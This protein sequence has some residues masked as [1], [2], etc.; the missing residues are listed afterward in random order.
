M[1]RSTNA[2]VRT[3][4]ASASVARSGHADIQYEDAAR[5][6]QAKRG[7]PCATPIIE[8]EQ[9]RYRT[10]GNDDRVEGHD[11]G[12]LFQRRRDHDQQLAT[13]AQPRQTVYEI[14]TDRFQL[15]SDRS[16]CSSAA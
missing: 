12:L 10:A 8:R 1:S 15:H 9:M 2:R 11:T 6:E 13:C 5:A 3:R 7:G 16:P 4:C 14:P